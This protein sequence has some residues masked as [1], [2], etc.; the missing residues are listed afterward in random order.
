MA[1]TPIP[2]PTRGTV[3][4]R[5]R[6]GPSRTP[7]APARLRPDGDATAAAPVL[8]AAAV[9]DGLGGASS[10]AHAGAARRGRGGPARSRRTPPTREA[11]LR[12]GSPAWLLAH[13]VPLTPG[14]GRSALVPLAVTA[15]AAWRV[16]RAGRAHRAGGRAP[17]AAASVLPALRRRRG[18]RPGVRGVRR[19]RWRLGRVHVRAR[20][21]YPARA[22]TLAGFGL[23]AGL[24]GALSRAA[25]RRGWRRACRRR[26]A[27]RV[28]TGSSPRCW[29]SPPARPR[30]GSRWRCRP[31]WRTDM[32][33]EYRTGVVG[34]AGLTLVCLVTR[35]TWPSGGPATWSGR[36]SPSAPARRSAPAAVTLGPV[37]ALPV[38]AAVPGAAAADLERR[39]CWAFRWWPGWSPAGCWPAGGCA[40]PARA[41][42]RLL[43]PAALAGPVAG[44]CWP[45]GAGLARLAGGGRLAAVGAGA[46]PLA[47]RP[48]WSCAGAVAAA[49]ATRA[50]P[51][52]DAPGR[53]PGARLEP[54][55][56]VAVLSSAA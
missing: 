10:S 17:A 46:W 53:P 41:V 30:P 37:P 48:P 9:T 4:T 25:G 18:G 11:V 44:R 2:M 15:L 45:G 56:P 7:P 52:G 29:C 54:V 33:R 36:G 51:P 28:R 19:G 40:G 23:L 34:Q 50:M 14:S 1:G 24:A 42:A 49:A 16:V 39:C 32:L 13:G 21:R 22:L 55:S 26:S 47:L 3:G 20:C 35:R 31:A 38:L 5:A 43:G 12:A 27:T 8:L 6:I